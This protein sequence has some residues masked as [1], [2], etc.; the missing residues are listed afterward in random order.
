[1]PGKPVRLQRTLVDGT[2]REVMYFL[3]ISDE[4]NPVLRVYRN[5]DIV[6]GKY[7]DRRIEGLTPVRREILGAMELDAITMSKTKLELKYPTVE[8]SDLA[9]SSERNLDSPA[10]WWLH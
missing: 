4:A 5:G 1:M 9:I 3:K 7:H 2:V 10:L 6:R 8:V